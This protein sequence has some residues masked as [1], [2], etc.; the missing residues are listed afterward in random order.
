MTDDTS[1]AVQLPALNT[2]VCY[3]YMCREETV[4][5][6]MRQAVSVSASL[7][8]L[9]STPSQ[10]LKCSLTPSSVAYIARDCLS[11]K[12]R[13][14]GWVER[15]TM[16]AL[17]ILLCIL[18]VTISLFFV[19][20]EANSREPAVPT[21]GFLP[22]GIPGRFPVVSLTFAWWPPRESWSRVAELISIPSSKPCKEVKRRY[23]MGYR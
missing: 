10:L 19:P 23:A 3:V 7:A 8:H 13:A 5:V 2:H 12:P 4:G 18:F 6:A 21:A 16:A 1:Q 11:Q 17:F 15:C 9:P 20:F 14:W 22:P